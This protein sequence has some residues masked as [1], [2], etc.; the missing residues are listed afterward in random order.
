MAPAYSSSFSVSVVLPASGWEMIANV[1]RRSTSA[2]SAGLVATVWQ[3][4]DLRS[5]PAIYFSSAMNF[6]SSSPQIA[7]SECVPWPRVCV[8]DRQQD[9][10]AVLH[11]LDQRFHHRQLRR[12]DEIVGGVDR[13]QR[14]R[15]LRQVRRRV[16]V[17]DRVDSS[18]ACRWRR[19]SSCAT[20]SDRPATCRSPAIVG[21]CFC[22]CSG[23]LVAISRNPIALASP[24]GCSV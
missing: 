14:R 22:H 11:L 20:R 6:T 24:R 4:S 7:G 23:T 1:R 21:N 15:D 16:V 17:L 2:L 13:Q 5:H 3:I 19:C 10:A 9:E 8:G 12:I 18:R